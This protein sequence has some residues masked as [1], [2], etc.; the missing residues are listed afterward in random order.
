VLVLVVSENLWLDVQPIDVE[1][2][3]EV[4]SPEAET[5]AAGQVPVLT[6]LIVASGI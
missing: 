6:T 2:E 1:V 3:V 5:E 4:E